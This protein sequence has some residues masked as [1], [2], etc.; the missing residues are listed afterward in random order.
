MERIALIADVHSNIVALK[1]VL[2]DIE[3]RN[4][5]KIFCLGDLVLKGASPCEVVDL[6]KQKCEVV[7]KGNCDDYAVN[8]FNEH[9]KWH[10]NKLGVERVAYLN[11]L[12]LYKDIYISGSFVRMFHA[13][14]NNLNLRIFDN[15]SLDEKL[16]L[17]YDEE[18][19]PDIIFYADIHKQYLQKIKNKTI[20][21]IGSVGNPLEISNEIDEGIDMKEIT[22]AHYCVVEGELNSKKTGALSIQFIRVPYNIKRELELAKK[23]KSPDYESYERE[24]MF[25]KYRGKT[26]SVKL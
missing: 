6:I 2:K 10:N 20:V 16:K 24:L 15:S 23:N 18:C 26:V 25:A 9:T 17:F 1:E 19:S 12:P 3:K 4:I 13:T 7:L 21:N 14:K 5:S 11:N 22:Q 8:S